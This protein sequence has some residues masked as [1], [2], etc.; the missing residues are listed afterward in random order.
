MVFSVPV[1]EADKVLQLLE[2]ISL[3]AWKKSAISTVSYS[4]SSQIS[5]KA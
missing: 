3:P 1:V 2:K 5:I 4:S